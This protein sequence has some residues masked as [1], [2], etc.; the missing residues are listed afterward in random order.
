MKYVNGEFLA[1]EPRLK[2]DGIF[3]DG[4]VCANDGLI[5][6]AAHIIFSFQ[7]HVRLF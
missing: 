3:I 2:S 7:A 4:V 1:A 5:G 6:S